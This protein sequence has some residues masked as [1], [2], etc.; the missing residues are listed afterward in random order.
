MRKWK[1]E[2][3]AKPEVVFNVVFIGAI[4]EAPAD[5]LD[6]WEALFGVLG[7]YK[8]THS[9]FIMKLAINY[10]YNLLWNF[11]KIWSLSWLS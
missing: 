8:A 7:L 1:K 2:I 9:S 5:S 6:G 11:L 10:E 3:D 4:R